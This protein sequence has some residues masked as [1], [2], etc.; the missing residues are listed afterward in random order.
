MLDAKLQSEE[1]KFYFFFFLALTFL[2]AMVMP[3]SYSDLAIWIAEGRQIMRQGTVYIH[4][5]YSFNQ[6][7]ALPYPWLS[8][9][10]YYFFEANFVIESIFLFHRVIPVGIVAF[11]LL[12]YPHLLHKRNWLPLVISISG[13]SMLI[14]D[15][16]ALLVLPLIPIAFEWIDNDK[17]YK[18]KFKILG[19]LILWTNLHGSFLLFLA[20]LAYRIFWQALKSRSFAHLNDRFAFF[21]ACV[22]AT[23][24][25]P[26][27]VKIYSY[28]LQTALI[29]KL[30]VTEWQPLSFFE[31]GEISFEM[32]FFLMT[33]FLVVFFAFKKKKTG[34]LLTSSF[35]IFLVSA[36]AAVRS[37]P[38]L[39][40]VLPLYWGKHLADASSVI[41]FAVKPSVKQ[42]F[43]N[44]A[45]TTTLVLFA[46]FMFS[47]YS[48][49]YRKDL[50]NRYAQRYD[51]TSTF[52]IA[53]YLNQSSGKRVFNSWLL[54]S[55]LIY[56]Q[57]NQIFI[58][59]RNIIYSDAT[60][61][62]YVHMMNN[63][64]GQSEALLNQHRID[65]VVSEKAK[66]LASTLK[67]SQN[68][69]FIMEDN[70]YALFERK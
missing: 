27:G 2:F 17:I 56:S 7:E 51:Y 25:N 9:L 22:V 55:F 45:I 43:C 53:D 6:T 32:L 12:R 16:P 57:P 40:S 11:W 63:I 64:N 58:D 44:R 59:T 65:Y 67:A 31:K 48:E 61:T 5:A 37:L 49:N 66:A 10:F 14:V 1:F 15:R 52:R 39:F 35:F 4:D 30:R 18:H 28:V 36:F 41:G 20:L 70:G 46:L 60:Y 69:T 23:L 29:S 19:L 8:S 68:W 34:T 42:V 13:L 62:D 21:A 38:L 47:S 26:W 24:I 54:G 50:P 33:V 3:F